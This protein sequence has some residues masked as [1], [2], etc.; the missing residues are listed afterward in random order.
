MK[1]KLTQM[2]EQYLRYI[3]FKRHLKKVELSLKEEFIIG[4]VPFLVVVVLFFIP[5][6]F[7][8][9]AG[10][11]DL[12]NG[13]MKY[14]WAFVVTTLFAC[15]VYHKITYDMYFHKKPELTINMNIKFSLLIDVVKSLLLITVLAFIGLLIGGSF[16]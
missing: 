16:L 15:I 4:L 12:L 2:R 11:F 1:K 9:S 6:S 14:F 10:I 7:I 3:V 13:G 5:Y 8:F